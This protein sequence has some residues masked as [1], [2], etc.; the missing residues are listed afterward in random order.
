MRW[1]PGSGL[2][3]K[4]ENKDEVLKTIESLAPDE[5]MEIKLP[6]FQVARSLALRIRDTWPKQYTIKLKGDTVNIIKLGKHV[7]R[8][9]WGARKAL[10]FKRILKHFLSLGVIHLTHDCIS[11]LVP[12]NLTEEEKAKLPKSVDEIISAFK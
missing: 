1:K 8:A 3:D 10:I 6:S 11:N 2:I 12:K 7:T 5:S 9:P 4:L